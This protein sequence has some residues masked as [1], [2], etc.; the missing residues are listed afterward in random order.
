[1]VQ[2]TILNLW[3]PFGLE[4]LINLDNRYPRARFL[5]KFWEQYLNAIVRGKEI[6]FELEVVKA[7]GQQLRRIG[8]A[9]GVP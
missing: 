9:G 2:V 3:K 8:A 5:R 4:F 6:Q 7:A 1:M